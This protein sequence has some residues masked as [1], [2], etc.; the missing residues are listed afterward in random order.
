[1]QPTGFAIILNLDERNAV[2]GFAPCDANDEVGEKALSSWQDE[3]GIQAFQAVLRRA[4][5]Q[6]VLGRGRSSGVP[7]K[8]AQCQAIRNGT[9][10]GVFCVIF[11]S[12]RVSLI[13]ENNLELA[14]ER[15]Q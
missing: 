8:I 10:V 6:R 2:L 4:L 5:I 9:R 3:A 12:V 15:A 11:Q 1:M 13:V 7:S 14:Q